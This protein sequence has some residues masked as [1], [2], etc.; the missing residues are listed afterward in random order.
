MQL[1]L[2]FCIELTKALQK[3]KNS[4]E[5]KIVT[6]FTLDVVNQLLIIKFNGHS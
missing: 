6:K 2:Q 4:T 5:I 3:I 1:I